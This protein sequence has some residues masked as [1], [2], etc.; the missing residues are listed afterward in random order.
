MIL[1]NIKLDDIIDFNPKVK[2]EKNEEYTFVPMEKLTPGAKFVID[3]GKKEWQGQSSAKF[4]NNDILFARIYPC[5]DNRKIAVAKTKGKGF[6]STEFFVLRAKE[7]VADQNFVYY[8]STSNFFVKTATNSYVGAS[9]RQRADLKFIRN[10]E[11][12]LPSYI[13]QKKIAAILSAYDDLIFINKKRI[14]VLESIVTELYKEWF[15]RFRFYNWEDVEFK[16]GF[17]SSW[18]RVELSGLCTEIRSAVKLED[19]QEVK[20]YIGLEHL[21]RNEFFIYESDTTESVDSNKLGFKH[22]DI[23]FG[24]IRPYL[25]KVCLASFD[26]V[27]STDIIVL[28]PK[29]RNYLLYLLCTVS[30]GAFIDLATVSA[31]GTKMPRADWDFLSKLEIPLPTEEVLTEFNAICQPLIEEAFNLLKKIAILKDIKQSLLPRLLSGK[32]SVDK[33]DIQFPPSMQTE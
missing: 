15:V 3:E 11:F 5:L 25:H 30:T 29:D 16:K 12:S 20:D 23:L 14:R 9:G 32:L 31:K 8:L 6:G 2:L 24:K 7:G 10:S 4:E 18:S 28:R 13:A 33:L 21:S 1:E 27:C 22:S 17:P 26:G 19:L